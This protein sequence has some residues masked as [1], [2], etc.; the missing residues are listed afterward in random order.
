MRSPINSPGHVSQA[1]PSRRSLILLFA[2]KS[3]QGNNCLIVQVGRLMF[4]G[5]EVQPRPVCAGLGYLNVP[6]DVSII[7]FDEIPLSSYMSLT[8]IAQPSFEVGR[9][10]IMLL[11]DLIEH[12]R[13]PPQ[14]I[15]LRDSLI[16]RKSC[17][18]L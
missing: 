16:I 11:I 14:R 18:K 1:A 10:S 9:N 5:A 4:P 7:G 12:R 8:T 15:L 17:R 2:K 3:E 13:A 6:E